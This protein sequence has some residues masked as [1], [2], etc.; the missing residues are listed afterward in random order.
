MGKRFALGYLTVLTV[1]MGAALAYGFLVGDFWADGAELMDN[2]WGVV[3]LFDVYVGFFFFI[4]W[5]WYRECCLG[6]KAFMTVAILLGGNL[7]CG[8]Y[9]VFTLLTSKG[10]PQVFFLGNG[11]EE[12]TISET[13]SG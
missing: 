10:D 3:S 7:I 13:D 6:A 9:A 11:K 5:V 4:G 1:V 8:I 12:A 2:P